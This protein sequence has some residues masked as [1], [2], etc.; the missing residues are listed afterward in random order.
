[1]GARTLLYRLL[2]ISPV[3]LITW[4]VGTGRVLGDNFEFVGCTEQQQKDIS[5]YRNV[6]VM[7]T[8]LKLRSYRRNPAQIRS[9]AAEWVKEYKSGKLRP[10]TPAFLGDSIQD[11]VKSEIRLCQ[12]SLYIQMRLLSEREIRAGNLDQALNDI[13]ACLSVSQ[14]LRGSDALAESACCQQQRST[15]EDLKPLLPSLNPKQLEET[16]KRLVALRDEAPDMGK[17]IHQ[18]SVFMIQGQPKLSPVDQWGTVLAQA[19][20]KKAMLPSQ[21]VSYIESRSIDKSQLPRPFAELYVGLRSRQ[22]IDRWFTD[23]ADQISVLL[24]PKKGLS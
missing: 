7:T 13:Y 17:L 12:S 24:N 5:A 16:R 11:G 15:L 22:M 3:A 10:L 20:I 14:V 8:P 19:Q 4:I 6:V 2:I 1:M 18:T 23:M 21:I 9:L